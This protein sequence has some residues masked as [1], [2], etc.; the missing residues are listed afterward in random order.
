MNLKQ[1]LQ[2]HKHAIFNHWFD[3]LVESYPSDT[4]TFI[5]SQKDPFSNPVG[6]TAR[7]GLE[8]IFEGVVEG[9]DPETFTSFLDPIIRIRAIQNFSPAQA[10]SFILQ[11]KSLLQHQFEKELTDLNMRREYDQ[12]ASR[13]DDLCL[14]S[15]NIYM[16]CRE[17]LYQIQA[18]EVRNRTFKVLNRS[19]L[20]KEV[21]GQTDSSSS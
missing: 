13:I 19:G 8:A 7:K 21:D 11:L 3:L 14:L 18:D 20:L 5:K 1:L 15:F 2:K 6:D 16:Q 10:V 17:T 12:I 4:A 9:M